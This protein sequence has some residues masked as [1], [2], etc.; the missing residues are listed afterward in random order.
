MST[1][2]SILDLLNK[3]PKWKR[4]TDAPDRVDELEK[5]LAALENKLQGAPGEA[6]PK[7]GALAM[8]AVSEQKAPGPL[9]ITGT[10]LRVS[11]CEDCGFAT[12]QTII[13]R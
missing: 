2:E 5:R 3:W 12:E 8:R 9:G 10:R 11:K 1:V 4:V 13:P 6:C 7:C